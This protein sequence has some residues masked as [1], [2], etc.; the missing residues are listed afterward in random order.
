MS[1]NPRHDAC[2]YFA[3]LVAGLLLPGMAVAQ[4]ASARPDPR[5]PTAERLPIDEV[6]PPWP[7][8]L[9][10]HWILGPIRGLF[11]DDEDHLWVI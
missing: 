1:D 10:I 9:P 5:S 7:P 3:G 8:S 11:V 6:D 2:A 4:R